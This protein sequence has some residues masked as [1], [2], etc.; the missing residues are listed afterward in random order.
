[1][2]KIT[3][4]T[5]ALLTAFF[6]V[7]S[8]LESFC[9]TVDINSVR[10]VAVNYISEMA[11]NEIPV[12][13]VTGVI[14]FEEQGL[15]V[16]HIV[17][18]SG[19]GF[20]I[21]SAFD[22]VKPVLGYC[23]S[24]TY[25]GREHAPAFEFFIIER[26]KNQLYH[27]LMA[28][29]PPDG[30]ILSEWQ[31]LASP[32]F[33]PV[34]E[35]CPFPLLTSAWGQGWPYNTACPPDTSGPGGHAVT[36]CVA[37]AMAQ[38]L[39][40][41]QHPWHGTGS[42]SYTP[43][44]HPEYG[45][46]SA[47][48]GNSVYNFD[49]IP[50]T[51]TSVSA[52]L[53]LLNYH[54]GVSVDMDYGPESSGAWG[55][56]EDDVSYA[57][58]TYFYF[59]LAAN[60]VVRSSH[61]TTW[62]ETMKQN[63][64]AY[65]PVIYGAE[66]NQ[67]DVGHAWVLDAY[68]TGDMFHCNWGWYG[69]DDGFYS[70]DDFSPPGY[71]FDM[72]ETACISI[73]PQSH[74][75]NGTWTAAGSP[76]YIDFDHYVDAGS[77]FTIEPGAEIIFRGR[78]RLEVRGRLLAQG[79]ASDSI[80]FTAPDPAIGWLGVRFEDTENTSGDTSRLSFCLLEN[81]NAHHDWIIS[82]NDHYGGA[83]AC[84]NSGNVVISNCLIRNSFAWSGGGG[85]SLRDS[86]DAVV[87]DCTIEHNT[88]AIG[89]GMYITSSAPRL[90]RLIISANEAMYSNGGGISCHT[91]APRITRSDILYNDAKYGGA[92]GAYHSDMV[93]DSLLM[94][95]N[96]GIDGGGIYLFDGSLE[97]S[98]SKVFANHASSCG[99]ALLAAG[100]ATVAVKRCLVYDNDAVK[101]GAMALYDVQA[102]LTHNTV[103]DNN[104]SD[105]CG[106]IL[107]N[108]TTG[109]IL[110]CILWENHPDQIVSQAA[111][112]SVIYSDIQ[113]GWDGTGNINTD[114]EFQDGMLYYFNLTWPEYPMPDGG[115][116]PCIDTGDPSS[117]Q[118]PDNT[119][120]DMG[121]LPFYQNYT[122][123]SGGTISGTLTCANSPYFVTGDLIV[124]SGETLELEPC[125][126]LMFQGHYELKVNGTLIADGT[127]A[128]RIIFAASDTVTGWEGIRFLN[129][130]SQADSSILHN[131]RI[132]F[133][134]A[135]GLNQYKK[136]GG[137]YLY[138]SS[139]LRM[140]DCLVNR[141]R[142]EDFGG[143]IYFESNSKPL[144]INNT[145]T[146]NEARMGGGLYTS[147]C[148]IGLQGGS[149]DHN[150][151]D[152]GG[153]SYHLG[154]DPEYSG[155][156]VR[157]NRAQMYG[158][159]IAFEGVACEPEFDTLNRCNVYLNYA[160][161]AGLDFYATGTGTHIFGI[162]VDT[163]TVLNVNKHFAYP[164]ASFDFSLQHHQ[165]VQ[166]D[167]DLYVSMTGSDNNSG[168]TPAYPL[169]TL[170]MAL[171]KIMVDESDPA[172]IF[173]ENGTYSEGATGEVFPVNL[174]S[175]VS[176]IGT[177]RENTM[178]YGEDRNQLFYGYD[179]NG[180]AVKNIRFQG[181][182]GTEGGA[183]HLEKY[184]SPEL[185]S[186]V[187]SA[188]HASEYGGGLFCK[189]HSS[190]VITR[191]IFQDNMSDK[192]G[193][194]LMAHSYS[195]PVIRNIIV[196]GNTAIYG[197]GGIYA[198]L[199][200]DVAMDSVTV[201]ENYAAN[202]AGMM[203]YFE[204]TANIS[205]SEFMFN[206]AT[207]T[208][209]GY[210]GTG[211]GLMITYNNS[212]SVLT[213]VEISD[214]Y[215]DYY[216]GGVYYQG[217]GTKFNSAEI[218]S[219]TAAHGGGIYIAG[220]SPK[221]YNTLIRG[222]HATAYHGGGVYLQS[223]NPLF[224]N[225]TITGNVCDTIY[226]SGGFYVSAS[227]PEFRNC[228]LWNDD[229]QEIYISSG[230]VTASY[231][232]IA[233]GW[234][235]TGNMNSDPLFENSAGHDYRLSASSPCINKGDPDTTGLNLPPFDLGGGFR[236]SGDTVDMGAYEFQFP[237][238][239]I[240]LDLKVFLEGPFDGMGMSTLI[241]SSGFIPL[242]QPF[243][244]APWNYPGTEAVTVIPHADVVDWLL[245]EL[246]DTTFASLA[247]PSTMVGRRA[248]FLLNDGT[249]T[250]TDGVSTLV[251][252]L[253]T[254]ED[255]LFA[256]VWHR[257]A[258]AIMSAFGLV[259]NSGVYSY[260]FTTG[261]GQ[262]FGGIL[263]HKEIAPGIWGMA[264]G[265]GNAD[266]EINNGDK[267]DVWVVQAGSSGYLSG[268]FNIDGQVNN[269]DKNDVWAPNTGMGGQ[270]PDLTTEASQ[271]NKKVS[272]DAGN[273]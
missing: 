155:V 93:C 173:L 41:W 9:S 242:S 222:N 227:N 163:F 139:K 156:M 146:G 147:Y 236:I 20:V 170:F 44:S 267:N 207:S 3:A 143:G 237:V 271:P 254:I 125:V 32:D 208:V 171:M 35:E 25:G 129:I 57:L 107:V 50:D 203:I 5:A 158:G 186:L 8:V 213:N 167:Q 27:V 123:L 109:S 121:A 6:M 115:K 245:I 202:G 36:G 56:G 177:D 53:A 159:G 164:L 223:A 231:S 179:D 71:T 87:K 260:D 145:I 80:I 149:L 113:G 95:Q 210:F 235:G 51:A 161:A 55:W 15:R 114:P 258:V 184:C 54:C 221:Y 197:G 91:A 192:Q 122:N 176:I 205:N 150:H 204:S 266:G 257:N 39:N 101:G 14:T 60:D 42:H 31:R 168:T 136:G 148:H 162:V 16:F 198:Y 23:T 185:D 217:G 172:N 230:T 270:V 140:Q 268:D 110:N 108:N 169:K 17:E 211:G 111:N 94:C 212:T 34:P 104:A 11:G 199:Y 100:G 273:Q 137:I 206:H 49:S 90:D 127:P 38:V 81:G 225:S 96:S 105:T 1:M 131:C 153:A 190:P 46:L 58:K 200:S 157:Y 181:G 166:T 33:T 118:D 65:R 201:C 19:K 247:T 248:A 26:L 98:G 183:V 68:Q 66:D 126:C 48:F 256:V 182:S 188:N 264:G 250:E 62:V 196:T 128:S 133:G 272:N 86:S 226:E 219:N 12:P 124:P 97:L 141:N 47:D 253:L 265:D 240:I 142:A 234:P 135:N 99:G 102:E 67:L 144:M 4:L 160:G 2:K 40:Y 37:T 138:G 251:F 73:F 72:Y 119:R 187:F 59:D 64:D 180:F 216:G 83:I 228:I 120:A 75:L 174:R 246:R 74:H 239:G 193:G 259:E 61:P 134:N 232:D 195:D 103:Y 214:N 229:P 191:S 269:G 45:T 249:V 233:G 18:I 88:A 263:A 261:A 175:Y 117:P 154:D 63:L 89:G 77:L 244:T 82:N 106:G 262:A 43:S 215:A 194:G 116:S 241:N 92:I 7:F 151:A 13:Y 24:N 78:Y 69:N 220:G 84:G 28:D 132:T 79:Q 218:K 76:Y 255:S 189:D 165:I 209:G 85:I 10:R 178:V 22:R 70:I 224:V 52:D 152:H 130:N 238:S 30:M 21:V 252:P 29:L 243:N 112:V